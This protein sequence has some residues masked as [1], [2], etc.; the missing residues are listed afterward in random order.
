MVNNIA[1]QRRSQSGAYNDSHS[2]YGL[3]HSAFFLRVGFGD[4]GLS[5][6]QKCTAAHPLDKTEDNDFPKGSGVSAEKRSYR[7]NN[8]GTRKIIPSAK[9][10]A[11]PAGHRDDDHIGD[12]I[13]RN[14]PTDIV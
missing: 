10:L 9:L 8:D 3:C 5:G 4:N 1:A 12:G 13:G 2:I 14:H 11:Q 6:Y 7:K